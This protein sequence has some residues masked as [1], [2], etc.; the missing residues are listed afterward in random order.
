MHTIVGAGKAEGAVTPAT[1]SSR[2]G[3]RRAALHRRDHARRVPPAH[4]EG[5]GARAALPAGLRRRAQRRGHHRDPARAQG[6]LRGAPRRAHPGRALVAAAHLSPPLHH[7]PLPARQGHRP[8]RRGR[9]PLRIENDSMPAE[10]DELR[11]RVMQLEIEREALK[12]ERTSPAQANSKLEQ[13][14]GRAQRARTDALT[15]RGKARRAPSTP[16][17]ELK[18]QIEPSRRRARARPSAAATR[19]SRAHP[20]RR[21]PELERS[22]PTAS[23]TAH[24]AAGAER[25]A[26]CS[27]EEVTPRRSPRSSAKWTGVPVSRLLESERRQALR[28]R[29]GCAERVVG[30]DEASR[31]QPTPCA[32]AAPGLGDPRP[33]DRQLP[34]PR[35]DRRRQ[36]RAVQG[37]G[38]VPV[39]RR[40]GHGAH[41]HERV[42]GEARGRAADRRAAR[43]RRLRG[44]RPPDRGGPPSPLL[45]GPAST[46][47]KRPTP[48]CSTCCCRCSTTGA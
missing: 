31:R 40:A 20:V 12:Q 44:G 30:Q 45:R 7:R 17:S 35:P 14:A 36:D 34:V 21:D 39:R 48:T 37:A 29:S 46:R 47:S 33:A 9:E 11:R 13:R 23:T 22:S 16:S 26:A 27:S 43:L 38:G 18:E 15:A 19:R 41:R 25:A 42:H 24:R 1:C 10:L 32:A 5:R 8:D 2:P 4:R 28:W 3:P 6:A